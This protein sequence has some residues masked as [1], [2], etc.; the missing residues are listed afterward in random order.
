MLTRRH[1]SLDLI[2]LRISFVTKGFS[3]PRI[4]TVVKGGVCKMWTGYLRMADADG[5]MRIVKEDGKNVDK[6]KK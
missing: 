3:R 2:R 5:K 4:L 1:R 6:P